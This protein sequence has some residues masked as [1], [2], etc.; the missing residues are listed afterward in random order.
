MFPDV[1][2][3]DNAGMLTTECGGKAN[4]VST[5]NASIKETDIWRHSVL[6]GLIVEV[7]RKVE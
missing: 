7:C 1:I 5:S 6:R 2:V 3:G 4:K